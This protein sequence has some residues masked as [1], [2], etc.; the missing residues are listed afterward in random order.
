MAPIVAH[1]AAPISRNFS[2]PKE[3]CDA[4]CGIGMHKKV[5][6]WYKTFLNGVLA[7]IFVCFGGLFA[8][9]SGGGI[10]QAVRT[11]HPIIPKMLVGLTFWVRAYYQLEFEFFLSCISNSHRESQIA[12]LLIIGFGGELFTGNMMYTTMAVLYKK[13]GIRDVSLFNCA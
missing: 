12:L 8:L 10:S 1:V 3:V 5:I 13:I 9:T 2:T 11:E 4:I 6:P 7:G